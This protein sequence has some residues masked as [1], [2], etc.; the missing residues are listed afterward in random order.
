MQE[1]GPSRGEQLPYLLGLN[2]PLQD[3]A[4]GAKVTVP[5]G[6]DAV[7]TDVGHRLLEHSTAAFWTGAERGQR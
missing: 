4:P 2:G 5:L 6:V 7:L 1:I 3:D